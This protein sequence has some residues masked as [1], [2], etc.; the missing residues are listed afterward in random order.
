MPNKKVAIIYLSFHSEQYFPDLVEALKKLNYPKELVEFV[1]VDN[2]HPVH[3]LSNK[4][5]EEHILP[6][7]G[8]TIPHVTYLPQPENG[9][10]GIGN[11]AGVTWALERGFD[12]VFFHN[13]DAAMGEDC[14]LKLVEAM[15]ADSS[16]GLAQSMVMLFHNKDLV[17][18]SGNAFHFLG[19]GYS[20]DYLKKLSD[21]KLPAVYDVAYASGAAL[22][23]RSSAIRTHGAWDENFFMYHEDM[24]WSFRLRINKHRVVC[25]RDSLFYH[26]YEF[27]KSI[28]KFYWMERNRY[29]VLLMYYKWPTLLLILPLLIPLEIAL[30]FFAIKGGWASERVKVMKYWIKPS[31]WKLWLEK[32]KTTQA[33]RKIPDSTLLANATGSILFQETNMENPIVTKFANPVLELCLKMLRFVVRW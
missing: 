7:S 6:I 18:T 29:A 8:T 16:I 2:P 25:V 12:Y 22:M 23:V 3:G 15:E 24:E 32:R 33:M 19:F 28:T 17:N 30:W 4:Y 10:F 9:G 1:I 27:S 14:I 20:N 13:N 11:N 5:V 26:K 21:L 31:S